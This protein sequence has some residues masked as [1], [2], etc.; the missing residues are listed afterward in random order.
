M[1]YYRMNKCAWCSQP[2]A[3][4]KY[5]NRSCSAKARNDPRK[6]QSRQEY[7]C[8]RCGTKVYGYGKKYCSKYCMHYTM[9]EEAWLLWVDGDESAYLRTS[10]HLSN[11]GK[12]AL[13]RHRGA[14]CE[15]CGWC[16]KHPTT[17][18]IP[19]EVDHVDGDVLNN[20]LENLMIL[21]PNHH[22]L[23]PT[24]GSL[25]S[26][27]NRKKLGLPDLGRKHSRPDRALWANG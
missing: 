20:K 17:G 25:N 26:A 7:S 1:Y 15:I 27:R 5:C 21:C 10:G 8:K 6:T 13:L 18:K 19:V 22:V 24:Y 3:N 14:A 12:Q 16:E 23:T 2:T 9:T 4:P 11:A